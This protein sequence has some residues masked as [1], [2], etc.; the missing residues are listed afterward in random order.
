MKTTLSQFSQKK[1][2]GIGT[3]TKNGNIII[4]LNSTGYD[5][6]YILREDNLGYFIRSGKEIERFTNEHDINEITEWLNLIM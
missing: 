2:K 3:D 6:H 4:F 1:I 5:K